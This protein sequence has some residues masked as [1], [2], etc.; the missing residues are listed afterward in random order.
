MNAKHYD[1]EGYTLIELLIA[2]A[3]A[4]M[5]LVLATS[6]F[7]SFNKSRALEGSAELVVAVLEEARSLTLASKNASVYGVHFG[8]SEIVL[9]TGAVYNG[10]DPNNIETE[11]IGRVIVS[12][13]SLNGSVQEVLFQR[14]T[15]ETEQYGSVALSLEPEL[16]STSVINIYQTGL[17]ELQ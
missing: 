3:V 10:S 16:I 14:L 12:D 8:V 2:I 4:A 5:L 13:T 15:G 1:Q 7:S 17:V 9:F 11:L 6:A